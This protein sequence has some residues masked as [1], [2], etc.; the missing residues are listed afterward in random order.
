MTASP[1]ITYSQASGTVFPLGVTTVTVTA[2]DGVGNTSTGS[3]TVTVSQ[4]APAITAQ[5]V[6][7]TVNPGV[8]AVLSVTATGTGPLSYQWKKQGQDIAGATQSAYTVESAVQGDEGGYSV[9]VSNAAGSVMS[10]VA[11]LT[12]N[13]QVAITEQPVGGK[14]AE[15]NPVVLRVTATGT[16]PLS[17]RWKKGGVDIAGGTEA[18]YSI[19]SATKGDAGSYT[20]VVSNAL[21]AC[22]DPGGAGGAAERGR[23]F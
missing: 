3:F 13:D 5:P 4:V 2:T 17:Y 19:P 23:F 12:V 16:G 1:V 8:I 20:V 10:G 14:V 7:L 15:G 18:V 9:L 21:C 11:V 22:G 6:G